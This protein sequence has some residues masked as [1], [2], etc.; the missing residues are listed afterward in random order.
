[1]RIQ[2]PEDKI[3]FIIGA[4]ASSH[5]G[6]PL[7]SELIGAMEAFINQIQKLIDD[8]ERTPDMTTRST[9]EQAKDLITDMKTYNP[10]NIDY[11]FHNHPEKVIVGQKLIEAVICYS[12]ND[13]VFSKATYLRKWWAPKNIRTSPFKEYNDKDEDNIINYFPAWNWVKFI[14]HKIVANCTSIE[15]VKKELESVF[16]ITFNYDLSLEQALWK[17]FEPTKFKEIKEFLFDVFFEKN[18]IHIYGKITPENRIYRCSSFTPDTA[19]STLS[20][21]TGIALR[22]SSPAK[23]VVNEE[24]IKFLKEAKNIYFLGYAFD[25]FNNEVLD[26]KNSLKNKSFQQNIFYT[27]YNDSLICD[28]SI[29]SFFDG[30]QIALL[31]VDNRITQITNASSKTLLAN[32]FKSYKNVYEALEKDLYIPLLHKIAE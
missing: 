16:I 4:G 24:A 7:G 12:Q 11:Y 21:S 17:Y 1:M 10:L 27:N 22:I 9:V 6:Y 25:S 20:K 15:D 3:L 19:F 26:L 18:I 31:D 29:R 2:I 23:T 30:H 5:F 8:T 28:S 14:H 13:D 32:V